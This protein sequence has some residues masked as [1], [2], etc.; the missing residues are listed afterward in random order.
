MCLG[1]GG[2]FWDFTITQWLMTSG[3]MSITEMQWPG[4]S[5]DAALV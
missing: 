3:M 5:D 4:D 1:N 2:V